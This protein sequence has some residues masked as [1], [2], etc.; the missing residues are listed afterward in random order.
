MRRQDGVAENPV[1]HIGGI[2]GG[3]A[4]GSNGFR[5]QFG[6]TAGQ[7]GGGA[8]HHAATSQTNKVAAVQ[9][10]VHEA[11]LSKACI[12]TVL[13]FTALSLRGVNR[14]SSASAVRSAWGNGVCGSAP[15]SAAMRVLTRA[16]GVCHW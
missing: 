1:P 2:G 12:V 13:L 11:L 5:W 14:P 8:Q 16:C 10:A 4:P 9:D 15:A 7:A 3:A 6:R